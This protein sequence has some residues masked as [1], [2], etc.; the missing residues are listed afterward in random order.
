MARRQTR[1]QKRLAEIYEEIAATIDRKARRLPAADRKLLEKLGIEFDFRMAPAPPPKEE[2]ADITSRGSIE[3]LWCS[4]KHFLHT[5]GH[6]EESIANAAKVGNTAA[7]NTFGR[8]LAQTRAMRQTIVRLSLENELA[9]CERCK[10]DL[11]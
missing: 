11:Q 8:L 7:V 6:L 3:E 1:R 10:G 5:E 9:G 2:P 4:V